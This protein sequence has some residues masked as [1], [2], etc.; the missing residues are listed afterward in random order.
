[1]FGIEV[2]DISPP[3]GFNVVTQGKNLDNSEWYKDIIFYLKSG[4]CLVEMSSK[5]TK[6]LKM[7]K[8]H[9]VLVSSVLFRINFEDILLIFLDHSKSRE[10]LQ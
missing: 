3:N 8:N 10:V 5:K 7:M 9:Y 2:V 1:M 6:T 4:Q